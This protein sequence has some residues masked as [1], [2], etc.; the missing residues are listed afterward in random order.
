LRGAACASKQAG[1]PFR[2]FGSERA[3]LDYTPAVS[4]NEGC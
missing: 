2:L 1:V 4:L 3:C